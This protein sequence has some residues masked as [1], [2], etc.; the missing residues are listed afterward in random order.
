MTT[1]LTE[2]LALIGV[3]GDARSALGKHRRMA[4]NDHNGSGSA[5]CGCWCYD[6]D[7]EECDAAKALAT[8][9]ALAADECVAVGKLIAMA[10]P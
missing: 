9:E 5:E 10:R 7:A 2:I 3:W 4:G 6:T 8:A 1:D